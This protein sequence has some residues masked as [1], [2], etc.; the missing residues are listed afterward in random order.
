MAICFSPHGSGCAWFLHACE[1]AITK[2]PFSG[3]SNAE[4]GMSWHRGRGEGNFTK[5][6]SLIKRMHCTTLMSRMNGWTSMARHEGEKSDVVGAK[7]ASVAGMPPQIDAAGVDGA[8][9]SSSDASASRAPGVMTLFPVVSSIASL[10]HSSGLSPS[11][12]P[13]RSQDKL[14]PR[15]PGSMN[16]AARPVAPLSESGSATRPSPRSAM[17]ALPLHVPAMPSVSASAPCTWPTASGAASAHCIAVPSSCVSVREAELPPLT[18]RRLLGR[19]PL[20]SLLLMSRPAV[21]R[22]GLHSCQ[23]PL[24]TCTSAATVNSP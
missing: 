14:C 7:S 5:R 20:E 2:S 3:N 15:M 4:A 18:L 17:R 8:D 11:W 10:Q 16:S 9:D 6:D 19:S 13:S 1:T 24:D 21:T 22:S 23:P 12:Q